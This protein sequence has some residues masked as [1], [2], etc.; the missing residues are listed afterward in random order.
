L[1]GKVVGVVGS[2]ASAVQVIPELVDQVKE[3]H[4]FQRH[5]SW[6]AP[7]LL[8]IK[9]WKAAQWMYSHISLLVKLE[10]CLFILYTEVVHLLATSL[11]VDKF[12]EPY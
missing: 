4:A 1:K 5:P 6:V 12:G 9:Y 3:L 8:D 11:A 2:G 7:K 10:R